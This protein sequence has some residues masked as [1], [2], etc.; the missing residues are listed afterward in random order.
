[1]DRVTKQVRSWNMSRIRS[2]G[3][4]STERRLR[5]YL[6]RF[7]IAGWKLNEGSLPG[8]PDFVF[9]KSQLAVFVDGCFW[10]ACPTCGHIPKSNVA[11]WRRKLQRNKNRDRAVTAALRRR[12]WLVIRIWEHEIRSRPQKVVKRVAAK[13]AARKGVGEA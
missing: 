3:T 6:V 5:A 9:P 11:Y 1:M 12:G 2:Q 4:R 10:H 8:R 7:G 13:I